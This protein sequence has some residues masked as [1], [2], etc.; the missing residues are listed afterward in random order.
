MREVAQSS[1]HI[2]DVGGNKK[3]PKL[4]ESATR[5]GIFGEICL[6]MSEGWVM[7]SGRPAGYCQSPSMHFQRPG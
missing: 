3:L 5:K 2:S 1:P 6:V 7:V 4:H